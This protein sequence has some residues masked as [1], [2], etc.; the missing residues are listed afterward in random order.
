MKEVMITVSG[1]AG[2]GKS[3]VAQLIYETLIA[4][5]IQVQELPVGVSPGR[6]PFNL[7]VAVGSLQASGF[8]V[9]LREEH[10]LRNSVK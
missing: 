7:G 2:T 8:S 10:T 1:L 4:H 9:K 3:V 6:D 5:G